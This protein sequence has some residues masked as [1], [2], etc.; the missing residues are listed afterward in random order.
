MFHLLPFFGS[1]E[2]FW[3][4]TFAG[5]SP[6]SIILASAS[7]SLWQ[8]LQSAA[9][10]LT[11]E[12][13]SPS[14]CRYF[15][16]WIL[17]PILSMWHEVQF[18]VPLWLSK[19]GWHVDEVQFAFPNAPDSSVGFRI[20]LLCSASAAWHWASTQVWFP[21]RVVAGEC[22]GRCISPRSTNTSLNGEDVFWWQYFVQ[23]ASLPRRS[24][25]AGKPVP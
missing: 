17:E 18:K 24:S 8:R 9:V 22:L 4:P 19:S 2:C 21:G 16:G 5:L 12:N 15:M 11:L 23:Y 6:H 14:L 25:S 13:V 3:A 7:V 20:S 1:S 10:L